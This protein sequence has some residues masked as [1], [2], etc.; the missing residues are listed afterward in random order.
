MDLG[1]REGLLRRIGDIND[2]GRPRPL[3]TLAEFFEGNDD[4]GSIGYNLPGD[5]TPAEFHALLS[6]IAAR[7]EVA[8]VRIEVKDMEDPD[9]WPATDTIWI[10]TTA[11]PATVGTWFPE[12][13][14]PD[15]LG[16]GL[17]DGVEPYQLPPGTHAVWAWY[18]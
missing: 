13:L 5:P 12:H 8:D 2:F 14:A 17:T 16:V 6:G 4:P 9:G 10:I 3:V 18:D 1:R 15:D 7:P 11:S